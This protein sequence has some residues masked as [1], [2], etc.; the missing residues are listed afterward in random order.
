VNA[1][2]SGFRHAVNRVR[3]LAPHPDFDNARIIFDEFPHRLAAQPPEAGQFA[4][5]VML[6]E[7]AVIKDLFPYRSCFKAFLPRSPGPP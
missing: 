4:D 6:L 1:P 2:G 7:S 3:P 5:A